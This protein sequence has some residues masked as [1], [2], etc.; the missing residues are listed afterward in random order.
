M[1]SMMVKRKGGRGH[2]ADSVEHVALDV[3]VVRSSPVLGIEIA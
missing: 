1:F 3:R 2:L